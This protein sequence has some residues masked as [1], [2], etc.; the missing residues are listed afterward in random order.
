MNNKHHKHHL[1]TAQQAALSEELPPSPKPRLH[2]LADRLSAPFV[3]AVLLI[4]LALG[5]VSSVYAMLNGTLTLKANNLTWRSFLDGKLTSELNDNLANTPLPEAAALGARYL[6]WQA[7]G[8]TGKNVRVGCPDWL[9]LVDELRV[10]PQREQNALAR[11]QN[12]VALN[13]ALAQR[14][15]ALVVVVVPDKS[16]I[17]AAHLCGLN[18]AQRFA[19]RIESWLTQ[20]KAAGVVTVDLQPVLEAVV[21]AGQ[22]AYLRTDTHW[23]EAGAE[24]AANAIAQRIKELN[25]QLT[26]EQAFSVTRKEA[27]PR[28]GDLVRLAGLDKLPSTTQPRAD[29]VAESVF[30][31]QDDGTNASAG[32]AA[33]DDLFGDAG[34]P[35]TAL[36]GSS[37]SRNSNFLPFLQAELRIKIGDFALD[38]GG[39]SKSAQAY[40]ASAAFKDT[41]PSL[42]VW[43][44][45]ER[46]L[47]ERWEGVEMVVGG[48]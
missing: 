6:L 16:R 4:F 18:R 22:E 10:Y 32:A 1:T 44:I 45:P 40:F 42:I 47:E 48:F 3:G 27:M 2:N 13:R 8:D 20:L 34:L 15:I 38:G 5:L 12:V 30:T 35:N 36:I 14:G 33:A 17:E 23:S 46:V 26:P 19:E 24:A 11:A 25:L 31:P 41:P 7:L 28:A 39:F 43:E 29:N 9:F 37:F 21:D